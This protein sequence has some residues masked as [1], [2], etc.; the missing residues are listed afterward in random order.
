MPKIAPTPFRMTNEQKAKLK[1]FREERGVPSTQA[2]LSA[3]FDHAIANPPTIIGWDLSTRGDSTAEVTIDRA[4]KIVD[5]KTTRHPDPH[6]VLDKA[7]KKVGL[8]SRWA[9]TNAMVTPNPKRT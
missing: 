4:G 6:A 7:H 5:I 3:L 8:K 2:A 1:A 9:F